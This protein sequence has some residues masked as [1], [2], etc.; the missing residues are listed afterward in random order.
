MFPAW[1]QD[2][3]T[4]LA[5]RPTLLAECSRRARRG[6]PGA[7]SR[8]RRRGD[9]FFFGRIAYFV[10]CLRTVHNTAIANRRWYNSRDDSRS[11]RRGDKGAG[12]STPPLS[13]ITNALLGVFFFPNLLPSTRLGRPGVG[14]GGVGRARARRERGRGG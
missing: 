14:R 4:L 2:V 10:R 11:R 5:W 7:D 1:L 9:F 13:R 8:S 6:R 12:Q 3:G